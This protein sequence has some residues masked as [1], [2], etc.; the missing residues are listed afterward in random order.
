MTELYKKYDLGIV[1]DQ[2]MGI[3][4]S[5]VGVYSGLIISLYLL[6]RGGVI[7]AVVTSEI[8]PGAAQ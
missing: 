1:M 6:A 8:Q 4:L 2:Y 3:P 7:S 5:L